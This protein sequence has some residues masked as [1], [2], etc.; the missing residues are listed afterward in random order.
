[1]AFASYAMNLSGAD[2][3]LILDVF[4]RDRKKDRTSLL[5]VSSEGEAGDGDSQL[6]LLSGNGRYV[7]YA[8]KANNLINDDSKGIQDVFRTPTSQGPAA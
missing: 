2:G 5:S 7:A 8:S 3:D 6:P 4:V 1:M